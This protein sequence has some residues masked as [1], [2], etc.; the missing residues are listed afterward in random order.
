VTTDELSRELVEI[1]NVLALMRAGHSDEFA[2]LE[3][4]LWLNQRRS[5]LSAL[6]TIRRAQKGKKVVSL[7]VWREGDL[8]SL[9]ALAEGE[10]MA[11]LRDRDYEPA[12]AS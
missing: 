3:D 8:R 1:E 7:A 5:Y 2:D 12:S 10:P 6:A 9:V 11:Q 4:R